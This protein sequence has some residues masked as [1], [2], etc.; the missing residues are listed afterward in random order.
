MF[1]NVAQPLSKATP[2]LYFP[3]LM[4]RFSNRRFVFDAYHK[5]KFKSPKHWV[6]VNIAQKC[7]WFQSQLCNYIVRCNI[8]LWVSVGS[9]HWWIGQSCENNILIDPSSVLQVYST[10]NSV[11]CTWVL[12]SKVGADAWNCSTKSLSST[13][14]KFLLVSIWKT[15]T[16]LYSLIHCGQR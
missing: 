10:S 11:M 5:L 13:L 6:W 3:I 1:S 7:S 9:Y 14:M 16:I 15:A 2:R 12:L 4:V 8:T